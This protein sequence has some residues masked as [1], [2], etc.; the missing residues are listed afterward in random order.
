[1]HLRPGE[2]VFGT[3]VFAILHREKANTVFGKRFLRDC[4]PNDYFIY[5]SV[6]Y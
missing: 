1:V 3:V 6:A 4:L 5:F 2:Q